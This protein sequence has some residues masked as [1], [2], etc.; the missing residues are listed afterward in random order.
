VLEGDYGVHGGALSVPVTLASG[1][2]RKLH[3]WELSEGQLRALR[4]AG[5]SVRR[6]VRGLR[7]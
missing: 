3:E 1:G 4:A 6:V 7:G 2:A 5:E